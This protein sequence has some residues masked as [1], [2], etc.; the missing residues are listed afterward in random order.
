MCVNVTFLLQ[1]LRLL[2][3]SLQHTQ[4]PFW[5]QH[6]LTPSH[7]FSVPFQ[8]QMGAP[9][10]PNALSLNLLKIRVASVWVWVQGNPGLASSLPPPT[11]SEPL[12]HTVR[13]CEQGQRPR[14]SGSRSNNSNIER[15]RTTLPFPGKLLEKPVNP[16]PGV[17]APLGTVAAGKGHSAN[18]RPP[19]GQGPEGP[20]GVTGEEG[21]RSGSGL[22]A[23]GPVPGSPWSL[24]SQTQGGA[25]PGK[26]TAAEGRDRGPAGYSSHC[27]EAVPPFLRLEAWPWF[28]GNA[29]PGRCIPREV[30][31]L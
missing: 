11:R 21:G 25:H 8:P 27:G 28:V 1:P 2:Q 15:E 14:P 29:S 24:R 4:L 3:R 7:E 31:H 9:T 10:N 30:H 5:G 22:P 26:V 13:H 19:G 12:E 18:S 20:W 6:V 17:R 23:E 16:A